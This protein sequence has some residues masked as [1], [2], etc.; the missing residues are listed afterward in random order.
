MLYPKIKII[1][2]SLILFII[3][4]VLTQNISAQWIQQNLPYNATVVDV[5]YFN[6]LTGVIK[7]SNPSKLIRTT[8]GGNNWTELQDT[9]YIAKFLFLN[10]SIGYAIGYYIGVYYLSKTTNSG[11][12][13]EQKFGTGQIIWHLTFINSET[14]WI[15]GGGDVGRVWRTTNSGDNFTLQYSDNSYSLIERIYFLPSTG[16]GE[17]RGW[18]TGSNRMKITTDGGFTWGETITL[19]ENNVN[20][21]E[22]INENT[23]FM[24]FGR[25]NQ[26]KFY[27]TTNSGYNWTFTEINFPNISI[28]TTLLRFFQFNSGEIVYGIGGTIDVNQTQLS[29]IVYKTTNAGMNWGYQRIDSTVNS[30]SPYEN[31]FFISPDTGWI[32]YRNN[33]YKTI[34]GGGQIILTVRN[35]SLSEIPS[36]YELFQNYPNPF[37]PETN[38]KFRLKENSKVSLRIY[39]ITGKEIMSLLKDKQLESGEYTTRID[40]GNKELSGGIYIYRIEINSLSG[41]TNFSESKKMIY[42]K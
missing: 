26:R 34:N 38:I 18:L 42:L 2:L 11:V 15:C 37:N 20:Q 12:T 30:F 32:Y 40:F 8:N 16:K 14:G 33:G 28:N 10:D 25:N 6:S 35:N 13:W 5:H 1:Y 29:A 22:F 19:P 7:Q 23:G 17:T 31:I 27:K 24:C 41:N 36:K 39:D 3:N 21:L 4:I 9:T